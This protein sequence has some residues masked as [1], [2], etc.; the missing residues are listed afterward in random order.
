MHP[1]SRIKDPLEEDPA[2]PLREY[3]KPEDMRAPLCSA[4]HMASLLSLHISSFRQVDAVLAI[5]LAELQSELD[6]DARS[7]SQLVAALTALEALLTMIQTPVGR[8]AVASAILNADATECFLALATTQPS[9]G[10]TITK[11]MR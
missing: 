8:A 9:K 1:L 4:P 5:D 3:L 11:T 2:W 10:T 7:G 6:R